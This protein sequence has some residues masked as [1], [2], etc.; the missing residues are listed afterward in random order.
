MPKRVEINQDHIDWLADAVDAELP[1]S[2]MADHVGCCVDTLKRILV[3]HDLAEFEAAKYAVSRA[4][5]IEQWSRPCMRCG[6]TKSR[7]KGQ[8]RCDN[9][10]EQ[11]DIN[12]PV[13]WLL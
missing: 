1:Y 5:K 2:Q 10:R 8:Y 4:S 12:N 7:A 13:D 6:D 9:C 3:R 11:E